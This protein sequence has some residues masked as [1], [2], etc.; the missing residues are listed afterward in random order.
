TIISGT[1]TLSVVS[2]DT[3]GQSVGTHSIALRVKNSCGNWSSVKNISITLTQGLVDITVN[4]SDGINPIQSATVKV[5]LSVNPQDEKSCTTNS[6]GICIIQDLE[7]D[8]LYEVSVIKMG[9]ICTAGCGEFNSG[10]GG[11]ITVT[12]RETGCT[13][14]FLPSKSLIVLEKEMEL[15]LSGKAVNVDSE[16][17]REIGIIFVRPDNTEISENLGI[18][19]KCEEKPYE[20]NFGN[21]ES[22]VVGKWFLKQCEII[23]DIW[24]VTEI[25]S[26]H[27]IRPIEKP[28]IE[29]TDK[30]IS[31]IAIA[32]LGLLGLSILS[33]KK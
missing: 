16:N 14:S 3:I 8:T 26:I 1:S 19:A 27:V 25:A 20:Y 33:K 24:N 9:Y 12:M 5:I 6:D 13:K 4:V 18:L 32:G 15:I 31:G 30:G 7:P 17:E 10:N 29:P 11:S 23:D 28:P 21:I 22:E 2:I